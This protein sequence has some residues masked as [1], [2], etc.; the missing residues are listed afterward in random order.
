M[1]IHEE[2]FYCA[3][4]GC[5]HA[6]SCVLSM[7]CYGQFTPFRPHLDMRNIRSFHKK[8]NVAINRYEINCRDYVEYKIG[9]K[10]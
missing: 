4:A 8:D 1:K 2:E 10:P 6:L 3:G 7:D 9:E 5:K